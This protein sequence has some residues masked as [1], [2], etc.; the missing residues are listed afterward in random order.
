[1]KYFVSKI[2]SDPRIWIW[3][4]L[5]QIH[6]ALVQTSIYKD[7]N[8]K[9]QQINSSKTYRFVIIYFT[10]FCDWKFEEDIQRTFRCK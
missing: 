9:L 3:I 6:A 2:Q 10:N 7:E 1:M 4:R 5:I 8:P